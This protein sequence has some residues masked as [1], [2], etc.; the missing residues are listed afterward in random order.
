M[1]SPSGSVALNSPMKVPTSWFSES[2][3]GV[4]EFRSMGA[5]LASC[6]PQLCPQFSLL[7][8]DA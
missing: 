2:V 8:K 4:V 5:E 3:S 7:E 6:G 1:A